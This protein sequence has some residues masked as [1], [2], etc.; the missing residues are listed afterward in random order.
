M[1]NKLKDKMNKVA[2]D[3]RNMIQAAEDELQKIR[4]SEEERNKRYDICKSCD[5]FYAPTSTC[6]ICHCFMSVKTYLPAAECPVHKWP[7]INITK[8]VSK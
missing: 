2:E 5:K 8:D 6:K 1:L 3:T 7:I 4:V